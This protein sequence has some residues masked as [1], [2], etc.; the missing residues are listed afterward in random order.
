MLAACE[1]LNEVQFYKGYT[2]KLAQGTI[3]RV[4]SNGKSISRKNRRPENQS[5]IINAGY[6]TLQYN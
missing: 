3:K 2:F 1:G 4:Q 6:R 5:I